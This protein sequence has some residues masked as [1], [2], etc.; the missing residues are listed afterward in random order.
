[1]GGSHR[2]RGLAVPPGARPTEGRVREA[3]FSIWGDRLEQARVLDLFA[4]SGVVGLEALGRGALAVLFVDDSL[5]AVKTLEANAAQVGERIDIRKLPL[6]AGLVRLTGPYDLVFADPPYAF[7]EYEALLAGIAPLLAPDGE[8]V[9][10]HSSRTDLPI[11]AGR[12]VRT[13]V[14]RYGESALSFYRLR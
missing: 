6:P 11:E 10:E 14:R 2:G 7:A 4:G 9:V 13:D 1:M 5:R 8:I 3:L 12:L